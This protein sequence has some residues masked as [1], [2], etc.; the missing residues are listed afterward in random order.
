M[1]FKFLVF[2]FLALKM[3]LICSYFLPN[4]DILFIVHKVCSCIET[5]V[6]HALNEVISKNEA[7]SKSKYLFQYLSFMVLL[8]ACMKYEIAVKSYGFIWHFQKAR[9]WEYTMSKIWRFCWSEWRKSFFFFW[10]LISICKSY[11]FL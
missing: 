8:H 4:P 6:A 11:K 3:F 7:C 2:V 9:K 10:L 5:S 1:I